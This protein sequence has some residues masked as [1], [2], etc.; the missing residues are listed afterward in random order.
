MKISVM[1]LWQ[2]TNMLWRFQKSY[3]TNKLLSSF[4]EI[5]INIR[6]IF[7]R[8][9]SYTRCMKSTH[10][11]SFRGNQTGFYNGG[12]WKNKFGSINNQYNWSKNNTTQLHY[13]LGRAKLRWNF[14]SIPKDGSDIHR[15]SNRK[16]VS[17]MYFFG[18]LWISG[19]SL[20]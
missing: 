15:F 5:Y 8:N 13:I 18:Y 16:W 11:C 20:S 12:L 6:Y 17:S 3:D 2:F 19:P 9:F 4:M 1:V 14:S 10:F 7:E